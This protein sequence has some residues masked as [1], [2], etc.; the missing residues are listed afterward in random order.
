ME[1][2]E[3]VFER[4][5]IE[6]ASTNPKYVMRVKTSSIVHCA[7]N[8]VAVVNY[9]TIQKA[10]GALDDVRM[11]PPPAP[12]LGPQCRVQLLPAHGYP[13]DYMTIARLDDCSSWRD[14]PR[15]L[16]TRDDRDPQTDPLIQPQI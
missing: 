8:A 11:H 2:F 5:R 15:P 16:R 1:Q 7:T 9:E 13:D 14:T 6:T 12:V 10:K 4:F 3:P